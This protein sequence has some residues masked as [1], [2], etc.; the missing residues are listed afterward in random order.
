MNANEIKN[1]NTWTKADMS[2]L[3]QQYRF[4]FIVTKKEDEFNGEP[5][6]SVAEFRYAVANE[7]LDSI[8]WAEKASWFD[9]VDV[10]DPEAVS[11][12]WEEKTGQFKEYDVY[13]PSFETI[14]G[15][16]YFMNEVL[17]W[18]PFFLPR[19][20]NY[21]KTHLVFSDLRKAEHFFG[22]EAK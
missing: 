19:V 3:P 20:P 12:V 7:K 21:I 15:R 9:G 10:S 17:C 5:I 18:R 16:R 8:S 13:I 11:N 22:G 14:M 1:I 4:Y 2:R 6:V